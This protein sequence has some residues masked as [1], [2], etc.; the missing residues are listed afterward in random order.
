[1]EMPRQCGQDLC[2]LRRE[3]LV[4][5]LQ[6]SRRILSLLGT[7]ARSEHAGR[8]L[9]KPARES[10]VLVCARHVQELDEV[11][12]KVQLAGR[13]RR[14]LPVAWAGVWK[15]ELSQA[16]PLPFVLHAIPYG[17]VL[18]GADGPC[19]V[20]TIPDEVQEGALGRTKRILAHACEE[21]QPEGVLWELFNHDG[22]ARYLA[23]L[24]WRARGNV[25]NVGVSVHHELSH[26]LVSSFIDFEQRLLGIE[27]QAALPRGRSHRPDV[28]A[29]HQ[30]YPELARLV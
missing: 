28:H 13:D 1:M 4:A 2:G 18:K 21:R 15:T 7:V 5:D 29:R 9:N 22:G 17:R 20:N 30:R 10:A 6:P 19:H 23:R 26:G 3:L 14:H 24:G 25:R 11:V 27:G 12:A 8:P 16:L